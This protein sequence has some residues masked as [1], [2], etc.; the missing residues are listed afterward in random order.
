MGGGKRILL[1]EDDDAIRQ[2]VTDLL[3]EA[4]YDVS[5]A[6]NGTE[7]LERVAVW[8]PDLI[9]LDQRMPGSD[10]TEFARGYEKTRPPRAP[11]IALCAAIDAEAWARSIGAAAYLVKPF[12]ID[13][14]FATVAAQLDGREP[15]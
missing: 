6:R 2:L 13:T 11:I 7:A 14:L 1:A 9:L 4:G 10:G 5:Q 8:R 15:A 3:T 12:D